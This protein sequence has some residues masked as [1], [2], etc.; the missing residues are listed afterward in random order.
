MFMNVYNVCNIEIIIII[1]MIIVIICFSR[2]HCFPRRNI[3]SL[4]IFVILHR[5]RQFV[6]LYSFGSYHHSRSHGNDC[7]LLG[8][9]I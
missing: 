4:F 1:I 5:S 8:L 6:I 3:I 7:M 2:R 9:S